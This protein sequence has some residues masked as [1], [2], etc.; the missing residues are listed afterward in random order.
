MTYLD[1]RQNFFIANPAAV[2]FLKSATRL[3]ATNEYREYDGIE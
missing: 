3:K 2:D 1:N